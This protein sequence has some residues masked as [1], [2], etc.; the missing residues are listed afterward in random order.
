MKIIYRQ[1]KDPDPS[2]IKEAFRMLIGDFFEMDSDSLTEID[3]LDYTTTDE[4][5]NDRRSGKAV[6]GINPDREKM[7]SSKKAAGL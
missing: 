2:R 7:G 5:L 3:K 6:P 1:V 4:I